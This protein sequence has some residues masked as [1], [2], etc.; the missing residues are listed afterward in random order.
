MTEIQV[1]KL[2]MAQQS[3]SPTST[4]IQDGTRRVRIPEPV[5]FAGTRS[6]KNLENFVWDLEQYFR[7]AQVPEEECVQVCASYLVGNAKL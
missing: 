6:A 3:P 1:L 2:A 7:A 4:Q 5:V